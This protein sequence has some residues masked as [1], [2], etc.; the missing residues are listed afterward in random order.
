MSSAHAQTTPK[1]TINTLPNELLVA[2]LSHVDAPEPL[3]LQ[4]PTTLY[5]CCLVSRRWRDCA[6]PV[7]WSAIPLGEYDGVNALKREAVSATL[8]RQVRTVSACGGELVGP[9]IFELA[10][11]FPAVEDVRL[12]FFDNNGAEDEDP[13]FWTRF[14]HVKRIALVDMCI[15]INR[16]VP[17]PQLVSL[18]ILESN[19]DFTILE[20]LLRPRNVPSLRHLSLG[21]LNTFA[22][23]DETQRLP[24]LDTPLLDQL[25]LLQLDFCDHSD[26]P[27]ALSTHPV[28]LLVSTALRGLH[29]YSRVIGPLSHLRHFHLR[30]F[31][32]HDLDPDV[33]V[34][35]V[36]NGR[37]ISVETPDL[38]GFLN[39]LRLSTLLLPRQYLLPALDEDRR[40][41]LD[42][43][44][45][46]EIEVLWEDQEW[47]AEDGVWIREEMLRWLRRKRREGGEGG[48]GRL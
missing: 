39:S 3:K 16:P 6:Q 41:I 43:C 33:Q 20:T 5:A 25:E 18:T 24:D 48:E 40:A 28:P 19:V 4:H 45:A 47:E 22:D 23:E 7:L 8:N 34:T 35:Q 21:G 31:S 9:E 10:S 1:T 38:I 36:L 30:P 13:E 26:F 32:G 44:A 12:F 15:S 46:K 2:I 42:A 29:Q 27:A 11:S 17:L 14:P 37:V